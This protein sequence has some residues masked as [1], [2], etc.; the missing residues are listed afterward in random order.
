MKFQNCRT[1]ILATVFFFILA[2]PAA[3]LTTTFTWE[4]G[5]GMDYL[6][7]YFEG[8]V[9]SG[10][11]TTWEWDFDAD[12][13]TDS[14]DQNPVHT[15]PVADT[16]TVYLTTTFDT[17]L[18]EFRALNVIMKEPELEACFSAST[19]SGEAPLE[20][21]FT[22]RTYGSHDS[23]WDFDDMTPK[24]STQNPTHNFTEPGS[25]TVVLTVTGTNSK[26]DSYETIISVNYPT[27][28]ALFTA[29]ETSGE[30]SLDVQ[31][32]DQSTIS[33]G[34]IT[35]WYWT[36]GDGTSSTER[37]PKHEYSKTGNYTVTLKVT[38]DHSKHNTY[39]RTGYILVTSGLTASFTA[40]KTEG[41]E[42]LTVK[43]TSNTPS[44]FE[45]KSYHWDFED[46]TS[47]E[48][49]PTHIFNFPGKFDVSLTVTDSSGESYTVTEQDYITV[50]T[51]GD[52]TP[53]TE[54]PNA[55]KSTRT[56]TET[57]TSETFVQTSTQKGTKIFGIPGTEFFRSETVR[58]HGLYREWM[59]LIRGFFGMN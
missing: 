10:T 59:L 58:F 40:D 41:E 14:T 23:S 33:Y 48:A 17:G 9:G 36:F 19:T 43:F 6:M 21:T 28:V 39:E 7:V 37:N 11:V 2:A 13:V 44:G 16:Y 4:Q 45:I 25:Y 56:I 55:A 27:P 12:G 18:T 50:K 30:P 5:E 46:G 35:G 49:N 29:D 54:T 24:D 38:S 51:P 1:I 32:T 22:D 26:T 8:H 52:E 42:P 57:E 15:F 53:T 20:V 47:P 31:F 3:A 34:E